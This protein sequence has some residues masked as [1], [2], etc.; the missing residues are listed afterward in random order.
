LATLSLEDVAAVRELGFVSVEV[1]EKQV[2]G[3]VLL[4]LVGLQILQKPKVLLIIIR[5][6]ALVVVHAQIQVLVHQVHVAN[7][8]VVGANYSGSQHLLFDGLFSGVEGKLR[9]HV[10]QHLSVLADFDLDGSP[11]LKAVT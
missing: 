10:L 1:V 5:R 11:V 9:S 3:A 4:Q 6:L 8:D 7:V 2:A